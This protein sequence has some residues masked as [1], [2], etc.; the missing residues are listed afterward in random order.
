MCRGWRA[1]KI[2]G[3]Q[4]VLTS[5]SLQKNVSSK[6]ILGVRVNL[7]NN[8]DAVNTARD[9][10]NSSKQNIIFTPNPE[11]IVDA[12]RDEYFKR[13]LN[14][15]D[16]N[17]CDGFG[18]KLVAPKLTRIPGTDFMLDL[19]QLAAEQGKSIYL[20]GSGDREVLKKTI[21]FLKNKFPNLKI[22]GTDP[23]YV[24]TLAS[25]GEIKYNERE[26]DEVLHKIIMAAPDILFVA[27]GHNKQEKWIAENL[28]N[29]PSI[30]IAMGVGGA[31]D[32][33]SQ[34]IKRAPKFFRA[35]GLEW[36]WRLI[37]QPIRLKRIFKATMVFPFLLLIR[38]RL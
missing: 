7:I 22:V 18:L 17:L 4:T 30:K 11:M 6:E 3:K 37:L 24:I 33:F 38:G 27:F 9:F 28:R 31:F 10:L 2:I 34:K 23:G 13:V 21:N 14:Q 15:G 32:Y 35:L 19:C 5:I 25:N 26:H 12:Q 8:A 16:L 36:L 1:P 20:L 29:L